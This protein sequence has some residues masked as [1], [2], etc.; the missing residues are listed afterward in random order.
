MIKF[1]EAEREQKV[2][3]LCISGEIGTLDRKRTF[4]T[5]MWL[6]ML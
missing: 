4:N 6:T 3:L 5:Q 1:L 2:I